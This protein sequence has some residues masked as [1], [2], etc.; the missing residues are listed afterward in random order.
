[1][2][3]IGIQCYNGGILSLK[4]SKIIFDKTGTLTK[5]KPEVVKIK[6]LVDKNQKLL[7]ILASMEYGIDH[8]VA[9]ACAKLGNHFAINKEKFSTIKWK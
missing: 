7:N 2:R 8:P 6:W 4:P 1:M 3:R 9:K 5:G